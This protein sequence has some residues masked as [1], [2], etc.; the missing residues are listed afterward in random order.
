MP[1]WCSAKVCHEVAKYDIAMNKQNSMTTIKAPRNITKTCPKL[2][3]N[4]KKHNR[5][6]FGVLVVKFRRV[7]QSMRCFYYTPWSDICV[8][9]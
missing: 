9:S 6:C 2:T 1:I 4:L 7:S 5:N 8:Q 3:K